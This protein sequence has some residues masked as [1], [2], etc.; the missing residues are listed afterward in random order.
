M[1]RVYG[2]RQQRFLEGILKMLPVS[3]LSFVLRRNNEFQEDFGCRGRERTCCKSQRI[4]S[5]VAV[6]F[7][8]SCINNA[9]I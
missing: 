7:I 8:D 5:D 1:R 6:S 3:V 9:M 4:G 2:A